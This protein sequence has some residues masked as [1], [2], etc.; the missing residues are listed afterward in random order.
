MITGLDTE[1]VIEPDTEHN[2][3]NENKNSENIYI[4]GDNLDALKHLL[5]GYEGKIKCIYI[6]PPYNTGSDGFAYNDSFNF[7]KFQL[8]EKLD[9]GEDEAERIIDI[10][11]GNSSSHSAWLTFIYPRLY[12]A[13]QLLKD[14][15]IIFISIDDNE[16]SQLK[17]LCDD[18]FGAEN[19]CAVIPW[20]KRTAKSDVPLECHKIMNGYY[21]MQ[22]ETKQKLILK[23]K[24]E[25]IMKLLIFLEDHGELMI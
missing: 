16:Q 13:R 25:N 15:G 19:F 17:V 20:R 11:S 14:D 18:I 12:L 21:V 24:E 3:Q 6:D 23:E 2:I 5:K 4:S 1:T 8:E 9:I 7:N 10:T 22:K